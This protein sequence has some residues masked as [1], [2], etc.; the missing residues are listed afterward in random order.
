METGICPSNVENLAKININ[1]N[2]F[3]TFLGDIREIRE[4]RM[5]SK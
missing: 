3:A 5:Q 4:K 2:T 1:N